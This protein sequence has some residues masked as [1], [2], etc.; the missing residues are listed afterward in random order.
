MVELKALTRIGDGEVAQVLNYL[1]ASSRERALLINF[2]S[3]KPPTRTARLVGSCAS[4]REDVHITQRSRI[5][6]Q[7]AIDPK[8]TSFP[9]P[10]PSN[11][12]QS[13]NLR[14]LRILISS[15]ALNPKAYHA[16]VRVNTAGI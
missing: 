15:P 16:L 9:G 7:Q 5:W 12:P 8:P 2:G 11:T 14:N 13:R 3:R 10:I 6:E 4:S 1:K